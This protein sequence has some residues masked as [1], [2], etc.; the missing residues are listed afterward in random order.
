LSTNDTIDPGVAGHQSNSF[1]YILFRIEDGVATI[2][3]NR[4]DQM[5]AYNF[6]LGAELA[7]A[8][9]HCDADDNVRA[10]IVTG[11]GKAFCAGADMSR[12]DETFSGGRSNSSPGRKP[13]RK[14]LHAFQVRKP[15]IA[16]ING[17]AVGIG[18]TLALQCDLRIVATDAKLA[19]PFVRRGITPELGSSSIL[20]RLIGFAR[21][22]DLM[23]SGR[24]I[25]GDEAAA[26][27]LASEAVAAEDVVARA[28]EWAR[29]V[30]VNAAPVAVALTKQL[31]WEGTTAQPQDAMAKENRLL[32]WIGKQPDAIE[33]V[34]SFLERRTPEWKLK[35]S[36]DLE[37]P[38][39]PVEQAT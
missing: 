30:A 3:L 21:A 12:G 26:L 31:L 24:T 5:N 22:A 29:D 23:L 13:A 18:L 15:V 32:A 1:K 39:T 6:A 35:V 16:A 17:H 9:A 34:R 10:V 11:A 37:D 19:F 2:T 25:R 38:P 4:P 8:Y 27:G 36:T 14:G 7:T 28:R 20:P 33:G